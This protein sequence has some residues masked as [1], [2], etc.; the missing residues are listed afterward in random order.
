MKKLLINKKLTLTRLGVIVLI[1]I[2]FNCSSTRQ[3]KTWKNPDYQAY[4][5]EKILVIGVSPNYNARKAFEFQILTEL[6]ARNVKALQSAVV[7]ES[8]FQD[9]ELTEKDI[10]IQI[11]NLLSKGYDTV[12]V[13]L[14]KAVDDNQSYGGSSSKSD[15]HLR[16][17]IVYY[18]A[19]QD[20]F[21]NQNYSNSYQVFEIEASM[22]SLKKD[23]NIALVWQA[24]FDLI[25]PG[26]T[27]E[28]I[29]LYTKKLIK[30]LE[31]EKIIPIVSNYN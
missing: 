13:S 1:S 2:V 8:S 28:T 14:V 16:R 4:V 21:I 26:S 11:N 9:S 22:Y 24:N 3:L 15:Y 25:D 7:F 31:K 10:E 5:P 12:L 18:L 17:S 30:A 20:D 29:N 19:H 6:N 27:S 23:S